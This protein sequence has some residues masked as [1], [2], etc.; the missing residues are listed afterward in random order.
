VDDRDIADEQRE[1]TAPSLR[2]TAFRGAKLGFA[3]YALSNLI[4]FGAYLVLARLIAPT[5][6]GHYA[7]AS[8]VVGVGALFAES[9][10][11]SAIIQR[12]DRVEEAASTAFYSLLLGGVL[13]TL[14]SLALAP[15]LG[16]FFHS[17]VVTGLAAALSAVMLLRAFTV[18]PDALLQRRFSFVRRVA[19]DPLGAAGFALA[20]IIACANGAGPWGLV[21]G[22][23]ASMLTQVTSA[24]AFVR[25]RPHLR[26]ASIPMWRELTAFGRHVLG[27]EILSRAGSQLDTLM[28]GRF[29]GAASLGQYRNGLRLA[30]QPANTFVS[31]AAYVLLPALARLAADAERLAWAAH[32][33]LRLVAVAAIPISFALLPLGEPGAVLL[34]GHSWKPAGHVIAAL[35]PIVWAGSTISACSE[36]FK[37]VG[38]PRIL[39]GT[40]LVNLCAM[41]VLMPI[42][43]ITLGSVGVAAGLSAS[44]L[45]TAGYALWR[46]SPLIDMDARAQVRAAAGPV[47]AG[48]VMAAAMFGF[49]AA[50][51]PLDHALVVAWAF[52]AVEVL[53]GVVV[54]CLVLL[55]VDRPRR[56]SA[57]ASLCSIRARGG[58]VARAG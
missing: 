43:A 5:D 53:V 34:L 14:A 7:A 6:F 42:T 25:F 35:F 47:L 44:Q 52:T 26:L 48:A 21:A 39:V 28:L 32:R 8:V 46:V 13:L 50:A 17:G 12:P 49:S 15:V 56:R 37:A 33:I 1:Q 51:N 45:L 30:Q 9:G 22:A 20:S 29:A 16:A 57:L 23:Y 54:Y 55:S 18:V 19:V 36:M 24:W 27:S 2:R 10:M 41:A 38:R 3:G 11:M 31:V 40:W 4:T 58:P